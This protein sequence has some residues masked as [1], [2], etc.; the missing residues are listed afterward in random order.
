MNV[1]SDGSFTYLPAAGFAGTDTFTYTIS[2]DG[3]TGLGAANSGALTS[4]AT[5]TITVAEK[6]WY[7]DDSAA[8]GGTG[9][10]N[11]PFNSITAANLN[12][13]GDLDGPNDYIFLYA[14]SYTGGLALEAGQKLIGEASGLVVSGVSLVTAAGARPALSHNAGST[15]TLSTNNEVRGINFTNS[16]GSGITGSAVGNLVMSD[17]DVTVTGGTALS[18]TTSG[19]VTVSGADNDLTSTNGTALNV[20]N[21]NIG[22]GNITFKSINSGAGANNGIVLDNTGILGGLTVTGT[23]A[24]GSGGTISG[25]TGGDGS[26]TSGTGIFLNSTKGVWL[27]YMNIQGNQNYGIRGINVTGFALDNSTIGTTTAN[28]TSNTA[29]LDAANYQGEGSVRFF[30]LLGTAT[31]S[32]STLDNGFSKTLAVVNNTDILANLAITNSVLK[33][34]L[35]A[36]TASDALYLEAEGVGT[37]ANLAISGGTQFTAF[38]Q[39]AIQ[40]NAQ[41]G[42]AMNIVISGITI[43]NTNT[44]YVNASNAM[45][46]NGTGTNTFVTFDISG[47]SFT[48]GDGLTVGAT[49]P[50]RILTAG[51]INGAGTFYGKI[52]T[53]TFGTSGVARSGT[54]YA[55]EQYGVEP[56]I[57]A[58]AK[59]IGGGFPLGA[60]LATEKA[61]SGMTVGTHGSTYGG[62]PLA[63]AAGQAV[64]DVVANDEFLA[65]VRAMGERLRSALEQMIPNHD[66]LFH[67]VRGMGLMLGIKMNS[68][69]RAFVNWLRGQGLLA[70]AA[71]D[72]VMRVLPPLVIEEEHIREFVDRLSEAAAKYTLPE[73]A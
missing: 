55:Y 73:A 29:D 17:V 37:T 7:V 36:A 64:F 9:R 5:V 51:M 24:A 70:V 63:M 45:V 20:A 35:T 57:L 72:K 60:C 23:G 11:S 26:T 31:I 16:A 12:G 61:A 67:S 56:D 32:N 13:A 42:A 15:L 50:G 6:V 38:R 59:G 2:D 44:A 71:G 18:V 10:S 66:H 4:T 48:H 69:S 22:T 47:S 41:A 28:G 43:K 8:A 30:N 33:N 25:K 14:G 62:N 27:S 40:T 3:V 58:S 52:R 19:T 46:F 53:S 49:N 34:S 68:D 1:N 54:F 39:N 21:V 65:H